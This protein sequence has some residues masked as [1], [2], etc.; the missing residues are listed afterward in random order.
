MPTPTILGRFPETIGAVYVSTD[1]DP[2]VG[3]GGESATIAADGDFLYDLRALE[4]TSV[5]PALE[6][7]RARQAQAFEALWGEPA[8]VMFDFEIH[9]EGGMPNDD[10]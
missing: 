9:P 4:P 8:K 1:G 6:A 3:I 10:M 2:E 7:F 5:G